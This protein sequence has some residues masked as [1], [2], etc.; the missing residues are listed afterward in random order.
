[1]AGRVAFRERG[2]L[3]GVSRVVHV[4]TVIGRCRVPV[5]GDEGVAWVG[6]GRGRAVAP[7]GT[8]G[9]TGLA[10]LAGG[11][12][13]WRIDDTLSIV[14][15]C[16]APERPK[17]CIEQCYGNDRLTEE[18]AKPSGRNGKHPVASRFGWFTGKRFS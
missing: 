5:P 17:S 6:G 18:G 4:V 3:D 15:T 1:M 16:R 12:A 2:D 11:E 14:L 10:G 8:E 13:L 7:D 9:F